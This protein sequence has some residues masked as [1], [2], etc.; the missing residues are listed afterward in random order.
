MPQDLDSWLTL[1]GALCFGIV[2]GWITYRTLRR[3]TTNGLSDIATVTG[4]IGGAAIT[5]IWKPGTGAF[6][7][8]CI[9]LI[10]GFFG[11]LVIA[12]TNKDAP[13]WMGSEPP[14]AGVPGAGGGGSSGGR[15]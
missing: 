6:G 13:E 2:V 1:I 10:V 12:A 8:Y 4:A 3:N 14:T 5:G 9:G 11:Y 15:I 7:A